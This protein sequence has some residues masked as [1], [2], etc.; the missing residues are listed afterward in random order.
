ML[1]KGATG[2]KADIYP[3]VAK[4]TFAQFNMKC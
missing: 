1:V 2:V 3:P 4:F